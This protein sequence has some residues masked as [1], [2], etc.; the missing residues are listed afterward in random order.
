M[1]VA[2][3]FALGCGEGDEACKWRRRLFAR[4]EE[5]VAEISLLLTNFVL[6]NVSDIWVWELNSSKLYY[7]RSASSLLMLA[8]V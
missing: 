3:M 5:Q 7:V 6:Y 2:D 4:E 1:S 8:I